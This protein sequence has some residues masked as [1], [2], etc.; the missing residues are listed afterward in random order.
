ME[1]RPG[2]F[3]FETSHG[4]ITGGYD[5]CNSWNFVAD[6]PGMIESTLQGCGQSARMAAY[7][8]VVHSRKMRFVRDGDG[9][10]VIGGEHRLSAQPITSDAQPPLLIADG[11]LPE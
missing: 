2:E 4:R 1:V 5:G 6:Q 11:P 3:F 8:A 9:L 10:I 7:D